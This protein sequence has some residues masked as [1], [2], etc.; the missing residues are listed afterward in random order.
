M[1]TMKMIHVITLI[2]A[3]I[4]GIHLTMMGFGHDIIGSIFGSG[5]HMT[6]VH[7]AIGLSTLWH[8]GPMLKT[9]IAAL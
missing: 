6:M 8:I 5:D 4:G 7:I 3:T 9:Q 1:K 2:L